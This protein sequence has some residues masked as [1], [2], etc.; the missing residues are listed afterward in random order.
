MINCML[1]LVS[2][3][4][5]DSTNSE[6]LQKKKKLTENSTSCY[7]FGPLY[8]LLKV[9]GPFGTFLEVESPKFTWG[10]VEGYNMNFFLLTINPVLPKINI[11]HNF[12]PLYILLG[13]YG[14]CPKINIAS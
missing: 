8:T 10:K 1:G 14:F 2:L 13:D 9:Q 5:S 11:Y 7:D 3:F 4:T 6:T 12:G